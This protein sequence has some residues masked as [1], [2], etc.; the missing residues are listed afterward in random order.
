MPNRIEMK[1]KLLLRER[2]RASVD[3]FSTLLVPLLGIA[4]FNMLT[5]CKSSE[6]RYPYHTILN[7]YL[8][9]HN[10]YVNASYRS[11]KKA[12]PS[13]FSYRLLTASSKSGS[14]IATQSQD[15]YQLF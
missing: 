12:F 8:A 15:Y 6:T 3:I 4:Q 10:R 11:T 7:E 1:I 9:S 14:K 13:K 5:V 2:E